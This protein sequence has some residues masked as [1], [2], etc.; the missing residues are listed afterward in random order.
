M[1]NRT[2]ALRN[3]TETPSHYGRQQT[4]AVMP[5]Q[6]NRVLEIVSL[7]KNQKYLHAAE[8][9]HRYLQQYPQDEVVLQILGDSSIQSG[10]ID[11]GEK[12]MTLLLEWGRTASRLQ[13]MSTV[14][15]AQGNSAEAENL[16]QEALRINPGHAGSWSAIA[17]LRQFQS[18]DPLIT[19]AKRALRWSGQ[20]DKQRRAICYA[21]CK[22][23][24]D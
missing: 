24:N 15:A 3:Q 13:C 2:A 14:R 18:N 10:N 19:K 6:V 4:E 22:A 17:N 11:V 23:M 21:L 8:A 9:A 16:L 20:T 5:T 1:I 7:H 12:V